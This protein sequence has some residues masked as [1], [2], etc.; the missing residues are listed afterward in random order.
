MNSPSG[1]ME[2]IRLPRS[3]WLSRHDDLIFIK[4]TKNVAEVLS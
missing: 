2:T 4:I 1:G 3:L